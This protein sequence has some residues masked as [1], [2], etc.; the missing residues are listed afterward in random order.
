MH[1]C[2]ALCGQTQQARRTLIEHFAAHGAQPV[3]TLPAQRANVE[4]WVD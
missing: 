1:R 2:A 3:G 4:G